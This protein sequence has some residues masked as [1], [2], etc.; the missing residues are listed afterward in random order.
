[1]MRLG[2]GNHSIHL[3]RAESPEEID[4]VRTIRNFFRHKD[5]YADNHLIEHDENVKWF[6]NLDWNRD[7]F[8]L[9]RNGQALD[10]NSDLTDVIGFVG[11]YQKKS[12]AG[13]AEISIYTLPGTHPM[14]VPFEAMALLVSFCFDQL[15]LE[16]IYGKFYKKNLKA[17]RFNLALG[18]QQ[19]GE[20]EDF[21]ITR[22]KPAQFRDSGC[23]LRRFV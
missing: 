23:W 11:C 4:M 12:P 19:S 17:I 9:I 7:Y 2:R 20:T 14:A 22:L 15:H 1:M 16:E 8:F 13:Q 18:F 6:G 3:T 10:S 5:V 21:V